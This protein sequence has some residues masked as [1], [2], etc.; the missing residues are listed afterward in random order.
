MSINDLND[1]LKLVEEFNGDFDGKKSENLVLLAETKLGISFPP[2]YKK[3]LL[4]LGCGDIAGEEFYGVI[5]DDFENSGIPDAIWMT[6][7]ARRKWGLPESMIVIYFDGLE[8]YYVIDTVVKDENGE[9][10]I[11]LWIPGRSKAGDKLEKIADD[12]GEFMLVKVRE[13]LVD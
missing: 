11:Y 1:A 10:A 3:F 8:S 12:F 6:I 9:S 4:N 5:H 2:T 7:E 13:A